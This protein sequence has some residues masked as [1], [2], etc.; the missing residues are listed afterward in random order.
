MNK[1]VGLVVVTYKD[2]FGSALQSYATQTIVRK[3]G[4]D[5]EIL[6]ID[7]VHDEIQKRKIKF[8][9]KRL[10]VK[11]EFLY[12]FDKINSKINTKKG[13]QYSKN[14]LIRHM[15]YEQFNKEY[16]IFA[17]RQETWKDLTKQCMKYEKVLVGSDQLWRPSNIAGGY[18]TLEFVP[19]EIPRISYST[20][21]GVSSIPKF[22]QKSAKKFLSEMT[23]ISV[24]ENTGKNLIYDLVGL[25]LCSSCL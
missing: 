6:Q 13:Q 24:R 7:G 10:F 2:N 22:Q 3:L 17:P 25:R 9:L 8:Y 20:S 15:A 16:F 14:M 19:K 11:D 12:I 1:T 5:T 18:F 23:H 21:F 4:F